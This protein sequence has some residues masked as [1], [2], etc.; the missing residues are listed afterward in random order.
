VTTSPTAMMMLCWNCRGLGNPCAVRA[1][2]HLVKEK[3]PNLVFL[4]ETKL[5]QNKMEI[6]RSKLGSA[7]LLWLIVLEGVVD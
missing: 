4:M 3:R 7:G 1:L 2:H 6:I 5:C